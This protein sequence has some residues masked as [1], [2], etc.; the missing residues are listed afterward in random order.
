MCIG[1]FNIELQ[2]TSWIVEKGHNQTWIALSDQ[3]EEGNFTWES[4]PQLSS[5]IEAYWS[6]GSPNNSRG[7]E[8]CVVITLGTQLSE[9]KIEDVTCT[10]KKPLVCQKLIP[11][12][13]FT[14]FLFFASHI[15][16]TIQI[17]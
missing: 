8:D 15:L 1:L 2:I 5:E 6:A 13:Q 7:N 17:R 11:G 10:I 14:I 4:G 3:K 16:P 9:R 12:N